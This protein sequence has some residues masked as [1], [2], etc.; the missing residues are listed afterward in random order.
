MASSASTILRLELQANGEGT[1]LWGA[2]T[3]TNLGMIESA[4]GG[5]TPVDTTGGDTTLTNVDYT[6]DEAKKRVLYVT[7]TLSSNATIIIPN[8]SKTY[9]VFNAT[10]GEFTLSVKTASGDGIEVDQGTVAELYCDGDDTVLYAT[11][12]TV[13]GTGA[14]ATASGA[15]ASA[16]SVTPVGNLGS[17]NV[18]AGL[19]ELQDDI[20]A[21][22]AALVNRQPLDSDL[23]A[24][25]ALA[26]TKGNMIIGGTSNWA[27]L[28]VGSNGL[29]LRAASG[30]STG[31][32][33]A[34]GAPS[35]TKSL[36][37]QTAAPTGW[38]KDTTHNDKA[39][40]VV[41][42]TASSGGAGAVSTKWTSGIS[43][44]GTGGSTTLT[45]SQIPSHYHFMFDNAEGSGSLGAGDNVAFQRDVGDS[46]QNYTMTAAPAD[47]VIGRTATAGSGQGHTHGAGSYAVDLSVAY[48]DTII[49]TAD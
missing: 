4:I 14:P 23:T 10:E 44:G 33:W 17:A 40:R 12:M 36:F 11:P 16:V 48:V 1:G 32:Q 41:S 42:G 30:Q 27:A 15:A 47:A 49:A 13:F 19:S 31:T 39:L 25:A 45:E 24:I 3:N 26:S 38:T 43:I 28:A 22:N 37:P 7:G 34:A 20:D 35:G 9:I 46:A 5:T 21:I 2:K 29:V 6:D 18:Q 8:A